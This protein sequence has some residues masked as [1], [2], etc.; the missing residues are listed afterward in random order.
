M[1]TQPNRLIEEQLLA[2]A[3]SRRQQAPLAFELDVASRRRLREEVRRVY[4]PSRR[5][6]LP[7]GPGN[8]GCG[9]VWR[10]PRRPW[11]CS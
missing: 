2:Y 6:S 11:C 8:T 4:G 9:S 7:G 3:E 5:P 10:Q 1:S